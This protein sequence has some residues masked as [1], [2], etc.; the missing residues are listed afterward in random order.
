VTQLVQEI[1]DGLGVGS[2]YALLALGLAIIFGVMHLVNFA[3]G[4]LITIGAYVIYGLSIHNVPWWA[5]APV[6]VVAAALAAVLIERV[7]SGRCAAARS[8]R[9]CSRRS[10][11]PS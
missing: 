9:C 1:V 3:H 4:E 5:R 7:A 10:A 2:T 8:S 11:S 6:V